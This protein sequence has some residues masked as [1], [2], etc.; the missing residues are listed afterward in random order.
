MPLE[1]SEM[2][3]DALNISGA[4]LVAKTQENSPVSFLMALKGDYL[5]TSDPTEYRF[6]TRY[7]P[8]GWEGWKRDSERED[9]IPIIR[10]WREELYAKLA[11]EALQR[12]LY[13]AEG[14]TR[15]AL[16]ANKYIYEALIGKDKST[17]G[18]PSNEKIQREAKKLL[19]DEKI[20]EEAFNRIFNT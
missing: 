3:T 4:T 15:D 18:R 11:S 2:P 1:A 10:G 6:A 13:S 17:V 5:K 14:E 19:E 16:S 20:K 12:I 7:Y 9:Y 8:G